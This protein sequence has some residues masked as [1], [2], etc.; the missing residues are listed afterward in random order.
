MCAEQMVSCGDVLYYMTADNMLYAVGTQL[1]EAAE[2]Q[3][4]WEAVSGI[5]REDEPGKG[6]LTG[7]SLRLSME[8]GSRLSVFAEYDSY[9][10]WVPLGTL[11]GGPLYGRE[12]PLRLRRCDHFRLR[13]KGQGN[14]TVHALFMNMEG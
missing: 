2:K 3:V 14:V 5:L 11:C 8:S 6:Y 13:L 12:V 1:G 4:S 7:V 9:G 10:T